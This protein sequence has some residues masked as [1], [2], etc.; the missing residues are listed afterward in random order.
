MYQRKTSRPYRPPHTWTE[1]QKFFVRENIVGCSYADMATKL[2]DKFG[3]SLTSFQVNSFLKRN[4]MRNGRD[5]RI[6]KNNI[7]HNLGKKIWWS[8]ATT[9]KT[10]N[11]PW[12]TRAVGEERV[13][14]YGDTEVKTGEHKWKPKRVLVWEEHNGALPKGLIV[15]FADKNK[16]NFAPENLLAVSRAEIAVMNALK[17]FVN[18]ADGTKAGKLV[19]DIVMAA[20]KRSKA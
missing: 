10:G 7:P 17:V 5:T 9:F 3:I 6:Q 14:M 16:T 8:S 4:K 1:E 2:R 13:T 19:A 20:N 12:H 11:R 18:N 15:I